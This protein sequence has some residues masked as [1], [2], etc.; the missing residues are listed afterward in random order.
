[1]TMTKIKKDLPGELHKTEPCSIKLRSNFLVR[2]QAGRAK[3]L[4]IFWGGLMRCKDAKSAFL[5]VGQK[6]FGAMQCMTS[7]NF[8]MIT[9]SIIIH[10]VFMTMMIITCGS[11]PAALAGISAAKPKSPTIAVNFLGILTIT[12]IKV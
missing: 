6:Y 5:H 3:D 10:L 1:M 9:I 4:R 12:K 2:V 7:S 11:L 8:I